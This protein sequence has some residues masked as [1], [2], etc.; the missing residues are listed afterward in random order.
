[1]ARR[2]QRVGVIAEDNCD[3]DSARVLIHRIA[4]NE[5]IGIKKYIGTGCG[6]IR[7]KC[8]AWSKLLSQRGCSLL[9][10]I[11]DLDNNNLIELKR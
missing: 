11:H 9:V 10:L 3:V 1:M 5:R 4:N 8:H 7:R 2:H 6:R